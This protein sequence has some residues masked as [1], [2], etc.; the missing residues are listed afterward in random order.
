[1]IGEDIPRRD[2]LRYIAGVTLVP[3]SQLLPSQDIRGLK[4]LREYANSVYTENSIR[5]EE[6]IAKRRAEK[7]DDWAY[8]L[9]RV[10]DATIFDGYIDGKRVKLM[11]SVTKGGMYVPD[12]QKVKIGLEMI[13]FDEQNRNVG[14]Q[15]D[16]Y[17]DYPNLERVFED[18]EINGRLSGVYA[19][20]EM[21]K[22]NGQFLERRTWRGD[23]GYE[24]LLY[25]L[26]GDEVSIVESESAIYVPKSFDFAVH[27]MK[28]RFPNIPQLTPYF[29]Q[30]GHQEL[31]RMRNE[32]FKSG[33]LEYR[34]LLIKIIQQ[35]VKEAKLKIS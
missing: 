11:A 16:F 29:Q 18:G 13:L 19:T 6:S 25:K 35:L 20:I 27:G 3:M 26:S 17:K 2:F 12:S 5:Y 10:E 14:S 9:G 8:V 24:I 31:L 23:G 33:R 4:E 22:V 7:P 15:F 32:A 1:M 34:A 28:M 21:T 30:T